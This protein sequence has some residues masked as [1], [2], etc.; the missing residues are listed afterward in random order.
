MTL[1]WAPDG[2][3]FLTATVA[4]RLRV[5]NGFHLYRYSCASGSHALTLIELAPLWAAELRA[6]WCIGAS[7]HNA[8]ACSIRPSTPALR[9][10]RR[11]AAHQGLC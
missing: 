3:L 8:A 1:E 7:Q 4:P 10:G 5:D 9:A 2:R 6:P 11:V